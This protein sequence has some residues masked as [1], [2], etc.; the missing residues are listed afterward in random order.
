VVGGT[1]VYPRQK[2]HSALQL[3]GQLFA[4]RARRVFDS[5]TRI[6]LNRGANAIEEVP[7]LPTP[8]QFIRAQREDQRLVR[9]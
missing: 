5:T 7:V 1:S 9:N 8:F 3:A 6:A 4:A 2:S